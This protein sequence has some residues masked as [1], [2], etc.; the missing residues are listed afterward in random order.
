AHRGP[1]QIYPA[2]RNAIFAGM[3]SA[4]PTILE[5]IQK[6]DIRMPMS[7]LGNVT[8]ILTKKRGKIL[9]VTEAG[10]LTRLIAEIPVAESFDL[11]S[12]LRSATV[13]KAFWGLEFSRWAPVPDSILSDIVRKIRERKGLPPEPPKVSDFLSP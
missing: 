2:V 8:A 5:P 6:L 13:G 10:D 3:L 4:R 7:Y 1:A 9:N 11:A 12:E